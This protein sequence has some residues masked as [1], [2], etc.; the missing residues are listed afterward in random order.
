MKKNVKKVLAALLVLVMACGLFTAC[1]SGEEAAYPDGTIT[2]VCNYGAGG[3]TDLA[4]R[5]LASEMES[6]L[7]VPVSVVNKEGGS[8][9]IGITEVANSAADGYTFGIVTYAPLVIAPNQ[10]E[11]SYVVDDLDY[12]GTIA[13]YDYAFVV[14][15][16]SEIDSVADLVE[17]SMTQSVSLMASGFPQP[18]VAE[19][20]AE[21][22][23]GDIQNV[24]VNSSAEAV[25]GILGGHCD[26]G[27]IVAGDVNAYVESGELKVIA[28]CGAERYEGYPD[29][30][31]LIEEGYDI[32]LRS[33]MGVGA[34]KG[35]DPANFE[36]LKNAFDQA[37][38]SETFLT[39]LDNLKVHTYHMSGE[40][41]AEIL[42]TDEGFWKDY[43]AAK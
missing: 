1:G 31:T 25:T 26:G 16:D 35:I 42:A 39:S 38:E 33:Y 10:L 15:A 29:A 14:K 17:L 5:A 24:P 20:L 3:G 22:T 37:F 27:V 36:I 18:L 21:I 23:G 4:A 43:F 30:P 41:F 6:I 2:L 9:T 28:T 40:E 34:P 7:G 8:G 13:Q 32:E 19:N 12:L 11:V